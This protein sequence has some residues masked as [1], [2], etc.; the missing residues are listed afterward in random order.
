MVS[1]PR[2]GVPGVGG[3]A[4]PQKTFFGATGEDTLNKRLV[5]LHD[6]IGQVTVCVTVAL[7]CACCARVCI[8]RVY[9]YCACVCVVGLRR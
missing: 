8:V 5:G 9:V 6:W 2:T 4:F 3:L 7:C 1:P